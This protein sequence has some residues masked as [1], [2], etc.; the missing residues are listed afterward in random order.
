M[1]KETKTIKNSDL[2]NKNIEKIKRAEK[3]KKE[4]ARELKKMVLIPLIKTFILW[5]V[6]IGVVHFFIQQLGP[7]IIKGTTHSLYAFCKVFFIPIEISSYKYVSILNFPLQVVVECTAYNYYLFAVAL[8]VFAKWK[9][10][11]KF[12]NLSIFVA[13]IFILNNLRF[14][15]LA[16]VGK[17]YPDL[18]D[19]I[20]DYLWNIVFAVVTLVI[21]MVLNEKS[22]KKYSQTDNTENNQTNI[23]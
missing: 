17:H 1:S 12:I 14:V 3:L 18:F 10:K 23:A 11:D 5:L 21:W 15:L 7:A 8:S 6:L 13:A 22:Q 2:N 19:A 4:K 20:H 16:I 9:L